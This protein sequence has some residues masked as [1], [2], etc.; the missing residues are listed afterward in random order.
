MKEMTMKTAPEDNNEN[1]PMVIGKPVPK[2]TLGELMA[3]HE[4][5][6]TLREFLASL[7]RDR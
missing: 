2:M 7:N 3:Y 1:P 6:G 5:N 4:R